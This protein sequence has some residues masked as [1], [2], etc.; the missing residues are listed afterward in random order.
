MIGSTAGIDCLEIQLQGALRTDLKLAIRE[1][2]L[3]AIFLIAIQAI[4]T[5]AKACF[6]DEKLQNLLKTSS[7]SLIYVWSPRMVLS[8]TQAHLAAE[9]AS[10]LGLQFVPLVDGRIPAAE[11]Q[12]ALSALKKAA[13]VNKTSTDD[14]AVLSASEA[15]CAVSLIEKDAYLH[16][17][18]AFVAQQG[19]IHPQ[20]LVGAMPANFWRMGITARQSPLKM[21]AEQCIA[22]N[23]FI[24]LDPKQAGLDD[25]KEV[26]LGA[27]ERISPDGRFVLRSY[28]GKR[29]T[30]VSVV[31]LPSPSQDPVP[32]NSAFQ[33]RRMFETPFSNE[34]FPVQG[35]WRY[36]VDTDGSHYEFASILRHQA[37]TKPLFKGGM[38]GFYAA[39]AE[40]DSTYPLRSNQAVRIRSLSWPN[41]SGET[42]SQGEGMLTVRTLTVD[43]AQ[44]RI[45]AD[46]GRVNLC[47]DRT[48]IDGPMYALPMLSVDGHEF[49]TLP[50]TP[51]AGEPTMRIFGL[52]ANGQ[53]CEPR[54]QF[55]SQSGKVIFGFADKQKAKGTLAD[56]A[57]EYR[58][59][60]WWYQRAAAKPF[61]LAPWE[62]APVSGQLASYKN[63]LASAF[64]GITRDGRVIYA[65]TWKRCKGMVCE[66]EGGYVVAD[67]WQSNAY[68]THVMQNPANLTK[69]GAADKTCITVQDVARERSAFAAFH[70]ISN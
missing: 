57:Y 11:W 32:A 45:L 59:Q 18:T 10:L 53:Q 2:P 27:Y 30:A 4:I 25:N 12:S 38:T 42:D 66:P 46:S 15:L 17:P 51:V 55:R 50:Q 26:A 3:F 61:N 47:L 63:V 34:A 41:A 54:A 62:D 52:G 24:A 44:Q 33:T 67:P 70:G 60:I 19:H 28:S 64:P 13:E 40:V 58:G 49:A 68:K 56:V 39:A 7:A 29:L 35:S 22:A 21:P 43:P 1:I 69:G 31:E 8:V 23:Q 48:V 36:L 14:A 9:Q 65:A 20:K 37:A 6:D 16:F 5:P